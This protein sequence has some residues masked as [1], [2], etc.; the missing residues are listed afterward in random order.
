M[1]QLHRPCNCHCV[2]KSQTLCFILTK[3]SVKNAA[4]KV[5]KM[6]QLIYVTTI[7]KYSNFVT[8]TEASLLP[9]R[10]VSCYSHEY[11]FTYSLLNLFLYQHPLPSERVSVFL[12]TKLPS[13]AYTSH[14]PVLI[15]HQLHQLTCTSLLHNSLITTYSI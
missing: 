15:S 6:Y 8:F 9:I 12:P 7:Y 3:V 11:T 2:D 5:R 14:Q 13:L 4:A 10:N 1:L